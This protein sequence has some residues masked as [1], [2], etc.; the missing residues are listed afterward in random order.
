[1]TMDL[2]MNLDY[3]SGYSI[4]P[5]HIINMLERYGGIME[6]P[7]PEIMGAKIEVFQIESRNPH[8]HEAGGNEHI[9]EMSNLAMQVIYHSHICPDPLKKDIQR[10]MV[11]KGFLKSRQKPPRPHYFP[12]L[13]SIDES[14]FFQVIESERYAQ[15]LR[16]KAG[17]KRR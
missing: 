4:E 9:E 10:A 15:S 16:R 3:S 14:V 8:L 6:S 17:G 13:S 2:E 11:G 5:Y 7:T 1:M 12:A